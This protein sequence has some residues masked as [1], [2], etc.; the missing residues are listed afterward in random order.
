MNDHLRDMLAQVRDDYPD[1][2]TFDGLDDAIVGVGGQWS[3]RTLVI[4]DYQ[5]LI[6]CFMQ[7][8]SWTYE[9]AEEWVGF[10]VIQLWAGEGTPIIMESVDTIDT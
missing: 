7:Q 4:Y 6:D 8:N 9:E 10:N 2:V 1:T 5:K 3:K